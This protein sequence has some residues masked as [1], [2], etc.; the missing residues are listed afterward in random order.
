MNSL[1]KLSALTVLDT[2]VMDDLLL[3]SRPTPKM[4]GKEAARHEL[5]QS[6]FIIRAT[7]ACRTSVQ[8]ASAAVQELGSTPSDAS[9]LCKMHTK[10]VQK[11]Q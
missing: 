7:G 3:Y 11:D 5:V 6:N 4:Y 8:K 9:A 10:S 2:R 1:V